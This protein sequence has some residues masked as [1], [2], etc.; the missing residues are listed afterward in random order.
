[1]KKVALITGASKGIGAATAKLLA[2]QGYAVCVNY[3]SSAEAAQAIVNE[4]NNNN[5]VAI[6]VKANV[7]LESDILNMFNIIDKELGPVTALIN[8]AGINGGIGKVENISADC[9]ES[10]FATNVFGTF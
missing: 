4:I 10:V 9:L 6:S 5:G 3:H 2:T 1:M 8:N 7:G